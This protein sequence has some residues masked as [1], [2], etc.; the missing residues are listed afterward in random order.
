MPEWETGRLGERESERVVW[1]IWES[2]R[3]GMPEWESGS[4][5]EWETGRPG[6]RESER[7]GEWERWRVGECETGRVPEW[8]PLFVHIRLHRPAANQRNL[9]MELQRNPKDTTELPGNRRKPK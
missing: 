4:V 9:S 3:V 1:E 7:V 6:E 8:E 5:P 2:W